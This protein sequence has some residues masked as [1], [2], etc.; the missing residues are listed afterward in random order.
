MTRNRWI[1]A[2]S[3]I[4][5]AFI[6]LFFLARQGF[7]KKTKTI[8]VTVNAWS[9][10]DPEAEEKAAFEALGESEKTYLQTLELRGNDT[11][12]V[13]Y[14]R[15][16]QFWDSLGRFDLA[17]W[18]MGA[19]AERFDN[20]QNLLMAGAAWTELFSARDSSLRLYATG[21]AVDIYTKLTLRDSTNIDY[22]AMLAWA[23]VQ[24][25]SRV[26]EGVGL[27]RQVQAAD[28]NH[29]P[30]IYML[31]LLSLESGQYELALKRFKKL[32]SL[33]PFNREYPLLYAEAL[34][35]TGKGPEAMDFLEKLSEATDD[36]AYRREIRMTQERLKK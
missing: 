17:A 32:L 7:N 2:A 16:A 33:Q 28:S 29:I 19:L 25:K 10:Y 20:E 24:D 35:G 18:Y 6:L 21:K 4:A 30:S 23:V 27:L 8:S 15:I 11:D 3:L 26:M 13:I 1:S 31:G 36:E 22:R 5:G 34:N 9:I 12:T 14:Q